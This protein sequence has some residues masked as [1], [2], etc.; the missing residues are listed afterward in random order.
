[1]ISVS[2]HFGLLPWVFINVAAEYCILWSHPLFIL[3]MRKLVN[4]VFI[5][6]LVGFFLSYF[7]NFTIFTLTVICY[8]PSVEMNIYSYYGGPKLGQGEDIFLWMAAVKLV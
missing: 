4:C 6:Y 3:I 1:M 5:V 7:T 8:V 2:E